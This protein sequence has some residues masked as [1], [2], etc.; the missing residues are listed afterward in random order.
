MKYQ[1]SERDR[2][3]EQFD[4]VIED[5][6]AQ[7]VIA[8]QLLRNLKAEGKSP[9]EIKAIAAEIGL[10]DVE[11]L[12]ACDTFEKRIHFVTKLDFV[13]K[14]DT[15]ERQTAIKR[16]QIQ[17]IE[18][19][20]RLTE[21]GA[22][23]GRSFALDDAH[24]QELDRLRNRYRHEG[25]LEEITCLFDVASETDSNIDRVGSGIDME[26]PVWAKAFVKSAIE[27]LGELEPTLN[28]APGGF[29][30]G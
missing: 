26:S 16:L 22:E 17:K 30:L 15:T 20:K 5:I 9:D 25:S 11:G 24:Y 4:C 19:E 8:Q 13:A 10:L 21:S 6:D 2:S 12:L 3:V 23:A 27:T 1:E 14:L 29:E 28:E 18:E 7:I